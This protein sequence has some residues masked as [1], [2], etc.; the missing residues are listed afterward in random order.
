MAD[1]IVFS[2]IECIPKNTKAYRQR[3]HRKKNHKKD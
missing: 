1:K 3:S 2:D